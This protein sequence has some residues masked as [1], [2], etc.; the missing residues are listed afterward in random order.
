MGSNLNECYNPIMPW[1]DIEKQRAAIR[2]HYYANREM[3]IQKAQ[4]RRREIKTWLNELKQASPCSDCKIN[5]PYF[6]MD[7]DQVGEKE[8]EINKL[9]NAGSYKRLE[10]AIANCELVCANC[11][12]LRT[13]Q[14][15]V[16]NTL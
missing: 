12:R 10:K 11:H 4:R 2:R 9:I 7:F 5:Y 16:V 15:I 3:Y 14:R 8:M 6:V 1:K 13:H